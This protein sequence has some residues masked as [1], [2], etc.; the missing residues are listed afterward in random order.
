MVRFGREGKITSID[1]DSGHYTPRFVQL[2][3]TVEH[4]MKQGAFLDQTLVDH[5]GNPVAK[6]SA[7]YKL[8]EKVQPLLA[9]LPKD[10]DRIAEL[11]HKLEAPN[12]T[13]EQVV[14][15]SNAGDK[16]VARIETVQKAMAVL[17]KMG[18]GPSM[19]IDDK[20][21]VGFL[22]ADGKEGIHF[23]QEA[24]RKDMKVDEFLMGTGATGTK[25]NP[26]RGSLEEGDIE[27]ETGDEDK[28][29][30]TNYMVENYNLKPSTDGYDKLDSLR[31]D[32][33]DDSGDK[34]GS[35]NLDNYDSVESVRAGAPKVSHREGGAKSDML[36]ELKDVVAKRRPERGKDK[37]S[38]ITG[39]APEVNPEEWLKEVEG[40]SDALDELEEDEDE[41]DEDDSLEDLDLSDDEDE[42][43][44]VS[45]GATLGTVT[46]ETKLDRK[47]NIIKDDTPLGKSPL[48]D[49]DGDDL[50]PFAEDKTGGSL[51]NYDE[52]RLRGGASGKD[53]K[54]GKK[55]PKNKVGDNPYLTTNFEEDN[56]YK[57]SFVKTQNFEDD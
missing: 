18:I 24:T 48:R 26:S 42:D 17:G 36:D 37:G 46:Y 3:Q 51:N 45:G 9:A 15:L 28:V 1:N 25:A 38:V 8:Y 34:G 27:E 35:P 57:D 6:T 30:V 40:L 16:I 43:L 19:K 21:T 47:G 39:V 29:D 7:P 22:S 31:G 5:E 49:D 23:R 44:G 41:E 56:P 52:P 12:T 53:D 20:A 10:R 50:D 33:L 13:T 14:K 11:L 2:L 4:L 32:K 55:K 54:K